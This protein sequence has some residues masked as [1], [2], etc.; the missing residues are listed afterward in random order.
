MKIYVSGAITGYEKETGK[1]RKE[2]KKT[3]EEAEFVVF[4][5]WLDRPRDSGIV[6]TIREDVRRILSADILL[7]NGDIPSWGTAQEMVYARIF[8]TKVYTIF[9]DNKK[10][11]P[12]W[13]EYHS[14]KVFNSVAD[15]ITWFKKTEGD[16]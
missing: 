7:V 3:L 15:F 10:T 13:L 4:D 5:P 2:W 16:G 6:G 11:V 12:F 9:T 1:W 8:N 14:D